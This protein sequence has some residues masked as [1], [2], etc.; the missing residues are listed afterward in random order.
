MLEFTVDQ[1]LLQKA[2]APLAEIADEANIK[3]SSEGITMMALTTDIIFMGVLKFRSLD[4][5]NFFCDLEGTGGVDL[6]R[7]YEILCL[8][9]RDPVMDPEGEEYI[10]FCARDGDDRIQIAF[11][12]RSTSHSISC[13]SLFL[14]FLSWHLVTNKIRSLVKT[15]HLENISWIFF[16][17]LG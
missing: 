4:L 12:N 5:E 13:G 6:K 8:L 7:L 17:Q 10:S 16:R 1:I 15:I 11:T 2:V 9:V 3:Y 14:K